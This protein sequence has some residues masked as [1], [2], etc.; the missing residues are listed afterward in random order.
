VWLL[1]TIDPLD[2]VRTFGDEAGIEGVMLYDANEPYSRYYAID[3]GSGHPYAPYPLQV[4]ID[5]DGVIQLISH[6]Y[7]AAALNNTLDAIL[8]E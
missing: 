8:A 6:Q 7:D 1:N 3:S 4:V 2:T 5:R